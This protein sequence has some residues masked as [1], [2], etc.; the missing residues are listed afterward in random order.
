MR[1]DREAEEERQKDN[2]EVDHVRCRQVQGVHH[3]LEFRVCLEALEEPGHDGGSVHG[4]DDMQDDEPS[5]D[6]VEFVPDCL[7]LAFRKLHDVAGHQVTVPIYQ[8]LKEGVARDATTCDPDNAGTKPHNDR[9]PVH[10]VP[11]A[12]VVHKF[13]EA[14][15][16]GVEHIFRLVKKHVAHDEEVDAINNI[17]GPARVGLGEHSQGFDLRNRLARMPKVHIDHVDGEETRLLHI[18]AEFQPQ[19]QAGVCAHPS[20]LIQVVKSVGGGALVVV[21]VAR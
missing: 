4:N 11:N 7:K 12:P 2:H 20:N 9:E 18:G 13:A 16:R 1:D 15:P 21:R 10:N 19:L 5:L 17:L 14:Q 6:V 3:D 8:L